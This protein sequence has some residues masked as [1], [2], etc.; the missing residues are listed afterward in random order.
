MNTIDSAKMSEIIKKATN[1]IIEQT[2]KYVASAGTDVSDED[3]V[4][5]TI[6]G[7]ESKLPK[8]DYK[9]MKEQNK[10]IHDQMKAD[11]KAI[12]AQIKNTVDS[13][14]SDETQTD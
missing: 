8:A 6:N 3:A 2:E 14:L 12:A 13:N 1:V 7:V 4:K 5:V 10:A 9:V 11:V